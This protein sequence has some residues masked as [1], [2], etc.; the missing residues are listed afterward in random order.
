MKILARLDNLK[1]FQNVYECV[2]IGGGGYGHL[3]TRTRLRDTRIPAQA[4][5]GRTILTSLHK[6]LKPSRAE[7]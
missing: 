1:S 5:K 7:A 6:P 4:H 2:Y 3:P